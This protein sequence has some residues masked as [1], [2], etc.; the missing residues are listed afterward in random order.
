MIELDF[1]EPETFK[2]PDGSEWIVSPLFTKDMP[3]VAEFEELS[4]EQVRL[5]KEGKREEINKLVFNEMPALV[6]KMIDKSIVNKDNGELLPEEYRTPYTMLINI[7]T[8]IIR[9]TN[10]PIPTN[11]GGTPLEI[12]KSSSAKSKP[13]STPSK[14]KGGKKKNS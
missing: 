2:T 11:E 12:R 7:A 3:L 9:V 4:R 5:G 13:T 6:N 10:G 14:R 1:R 8:V